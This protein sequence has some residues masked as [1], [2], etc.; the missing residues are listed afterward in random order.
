MENRKYC[1]YNQTSESFLSLGVS[2]AGGSMD[3]LQ[4]AVGR[5]PRYTSE[6][7]WITRLGGLHTLGVFA[8][9]D[10]IYLDAALKVL[11]TIEG[12]PTLR[13][14]PAKSGAATIL[15]MPEHTIGFSQT[16]VGHQLVICV[17]EEMEL[18]LR[19]M[20]RQDGGPAEEGPAVKVRLA[21]GTLNDRRASMRARWPRL[22]A[23]DARGSA[24][25]VHE[26]RDISVSGVYL[27]TGERWPIGAE[28]HMSLQRTD[29]LDDHSMIPIT[30]QLRVARWGEDGMGLEF[31]QADAEQTALIAM[32]VR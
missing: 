30:V 20:P 12:F 10:L 27:M 5:V 7:R 2:P 6:G 17:A 11:S 32:Q 23:F 14:A 15:E 8:P 19:S 18:R 13:F 28:V 22:V 21:T 16:R 9:R 4:G 1:V 25:D 3:W 29:G 26:V 31:L 24:S